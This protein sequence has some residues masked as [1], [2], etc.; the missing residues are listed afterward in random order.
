MTAYAS[1]NLYT[2]D[3]LSRSRIGR[4]DGGSVR[5]LERVVTLDPVGHEGGRHG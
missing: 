2:E 4:E 1:V 5:P 3:S